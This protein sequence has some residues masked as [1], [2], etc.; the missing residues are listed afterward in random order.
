MLVLGEM[1]VYT[2]ED[3]EGVKPVFFDIYTHADETWQVFRDDVAVGRPVPDRE[4]HMKMAD[5]DWRRYC[6]TNLVF[7]W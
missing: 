2:A 4:D 1:D 5:G 6:L 7:N 3:V